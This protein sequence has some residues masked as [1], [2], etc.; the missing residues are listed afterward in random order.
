VTFETLSSGVELSREGF[1]ASVWARV[2]LAGLE[3]HRVVAL[4][5]PTKLQ[6]AFE[7]AVANGT[8]ERLLETLHNLL[9]PLGCTHAADEFRERLGAEL[10]GGL[11]E[12]RE[13]SLPKLTRELGL[14][15]HLQDDLPQDQLQHTI[16]VHITPDFRTVWVVV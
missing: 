4:E 11:R 12:G 14:E 7:L 3:L 1:A 9:A 5:L 13:P 2:R 6:D 10:A 8:K 15:V 16:H